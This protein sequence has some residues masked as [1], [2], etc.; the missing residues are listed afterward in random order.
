VS[1]RA[2]QEL[3]ALGFTVV[4]NLPPTLGQPKPE[5]RGAAAG[6]R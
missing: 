3:K 2:K 1:D 4:E 6:A 5:A